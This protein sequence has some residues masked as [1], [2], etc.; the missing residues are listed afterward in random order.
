[1][2]KIL[3]TWLERASGGLFGLAG[4]SSLVSLIYEAAADRSDGRGHAQSGEFVDVC[5]G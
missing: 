3:T 5:G 1:M 2:T 4:L